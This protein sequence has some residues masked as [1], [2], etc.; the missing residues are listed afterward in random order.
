[1]RVKKKLWGTRATEPLSK[2]KKKKK[3]KLYKYKERERETETDIISAA[4]LSSPIGGRRIKNGQRM[5]SPNHR[6]KQGREAWSIHLSLSLLPPLMAYTSKRATGPIYKDNSQYKNISNLPSTDDKQDRY[7]IIILE[8]RRSQRAT[9]D[10]AFAHLFFLSP[11]FLS[12]AYQ[13]PYLCIHAHQEAKEK[14]R[15][16]AQTKDIGAI[17]RLSFPLSN[18]RTLRDLSTQ[19]YPYL[20]SHAFQVY[21]LLFLSVFFSFQL[22]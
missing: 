11:K 20:Q 15:R 3:K 9:Y 8:K 21:K 1:M 18:H 16:N 17:T 22:A 5:R 6:E 13:Q 10:L 7:I 12:P 2:F 4:V 14:K 19:T